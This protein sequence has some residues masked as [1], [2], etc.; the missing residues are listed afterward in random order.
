M[1]RQ[2]PQIVPLEPEPVLE[3]DSVLVGKRVCIQGPFP[4]RGAVVQDGI[5][6]VEPEERLLCSG[7]VGVPVV[8]VPDVDGRR[9]GIQDPSAGDVERL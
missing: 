1:A 7:A 9:V 5:V 3:D 8:I 2:L 6:E 4:G